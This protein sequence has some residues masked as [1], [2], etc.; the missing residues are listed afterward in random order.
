MSRF[1]RSTLI[2]AVFFGLEKVLGFVRQ[3][4]TA[5]QF[6]L[7]PEL[8]A[9][10]AANNLPD[11]LFAL[12]SGGALAIAFIPVLTETLQK[13]DRQAAWDLFSRI[14]N[15]MFLITAGIALLL[16]VLAGFLV[17]QVVTPGFSPQQQVLVTN[18]MRL[19]LIATLIFSVSGLVI[20]G[21]Q[22]N[23]HFLLPAMA[24]SMYDLG[25]L[26]GVIILAPEAPYHLGPISLP[27]FGM[28]IYG[29]VYGSIIGAVLFLLIQLPGLVKYKFHWTPAIN[30]HHSGVRKVLVLMGPRVLT[31]L[32]IQLVFI[33]T[34]SIA[35]W[36]APGS[37]SA[38]VYGWLFMQV[39]E[40]LVGTTIGTVLLP[41]I[42]EH[43][44]REQQESFR[45]SLNKALRIILALTIPSAVL[46]GVGIRPLVGIL[47]FDAAG[48][49]M[50]V[51]VTRGFLVGLMAHSLIEVA[52]RA[53]YAQQNAMIPLGASAVATVTF[54]ILAIG[55]GYTLG[56]PGI[57]LANALAYTA[58]ATLLW[59][60]LSRRFSGV[61]A[62]RNTLVR[63]IPVALCGGLIVFG[64]L[65]LSLPL[66]D[67]F[68]G[69]IALGLGGL[70]ALPFIL[71]ELKL[72]V[73]M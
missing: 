2:V 27:N 7:S 39:P 25:M 13:Q 32:F 37:V 61:L 16:A 1:A 5:R 44:A 8:D 50:V 11:L 72:L 4:I 15:L 53:F 12:I 56:A 41:T 29:L 18:I 26:F 45:Q 67:I 10:N 33:A 48:T 23:Q 60:L 40:T 51:W 65:Q 38:L 42:S 30:L 71:P 68:L 47:G 57:A 6:G 19:D 21:L 73:K 52:A 49:E 62:A 9:F 64:L 69:I 63:A 35:S 17:S 54:V 31:V 3:V 43:L 20:A 55:F 22:A 34:D 70:F 28:G 58:E 59:F 46:V 14:A 66:S 36:L 24:P